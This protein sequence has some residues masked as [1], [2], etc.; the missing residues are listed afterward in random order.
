MP[1]QLSA[2]DWQPLS[3]SQGTK[4]PRLFEWACLPIWHQ[5]TDD[6]WHSLLIRRPLDPSDDPSVFPF[7]LFAEN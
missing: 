7:F 6:G 4:G 2:S 5:G 1:A 3:M